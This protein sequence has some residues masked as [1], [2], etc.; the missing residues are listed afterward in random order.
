MGQL[1]LTFCG[2]YGG[3]APPFPTSTAPR[4]SRRQNFGTYKVIFQR[5]G[6]IGGVVDAHGRQSR[7]RFRHPVPAGPIP[8]STPTDPNLRI[9]S[10]C[11][12]RRLPPRIPPAHRRGGRARR[13]LRS[14]PASSSGNQTISSPASKPRRAS[15][16]PIS[17]S[18]APRA[19]R[20]W[21]S[22]M[23][24]PTTRPSAPPSARWAA[25]GVS[26]RRATS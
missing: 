5:G 1:T 8:M 11:A 17:A 16:F 12:R 14:Q 26:S 19:S 15:S 4:F 24:P 6:Q 21:P 9:P 2:K 22:P 18:S 25:S 13:R 7:A 23:A 3:K 10:S 20:A